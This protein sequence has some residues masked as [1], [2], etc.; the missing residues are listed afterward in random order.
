MLALLQG[1]TNPAHLLAGDRGDQRHPIAVG[2]D[3]ADD[4]D[5]KNEQGDDYSAG[6]TAGLST[7]RVPTA[8]AA[9]A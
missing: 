4:E 3:A 5:E 7:I 8:S 2:Q 9:A 6:G 1:A